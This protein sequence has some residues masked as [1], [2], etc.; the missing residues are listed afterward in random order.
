MIQLVA[1]APAPAPPRS[2]TP[3]I[4]TTDAGTD[5]DDQWD[6]ALT[7]LCPE[8][9]LLG[10]VGSHAPNLQPPASHTSATVSRDVL[11]HMPLQQ[12][13]PVLEGSSVPLNDRQTPLPN[14][15]VRFILEQSRGYDK[16]HRLNVFVLGPATDVASALL[17]DPTVA[18]RISVTAMAFNNYSEGTDGWNVA[19]DVKAW[20]VLLDSTTPIVVGDGQTT[21]R[22]LLLSRQQAAGLMEPHGATGHYLDGLF[23]NW[24]DN[25]ADQCQRDTGSKDTWPVWDC[26]TAAYH[27]GH[28]Q[29]VDLPRPEL[30]DNVTFRHP[31]PGE[32]RGTI[33]WVTS[34][35]APAL[36]NRF[37][38]QI[39]A[40]SQQSGK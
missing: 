27:L 14:D 15:G 24:L 31:G 7:S 28:T 4:I 1:T 2:P 22:D 33:R 30:L 3:V 17:V 35:D 34:I 26:V 5:M 18:D 20:Q 36:W 32:N 6:I 23:T 11:A 10:V 40:A 21:L 29:W 8:F 16:D 12:T 39:D 9:K 13:P 38:R 37:T 19:N 25:H